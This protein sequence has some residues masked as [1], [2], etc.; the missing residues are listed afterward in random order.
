MPI[1][2]QSRT[3]DFFR[4]SGPRL[5]F[6]FSAWWTLVY[7]APLVIYL[8]IRGGGVD[9]PAGWILQGVLG[10]LG[11]IS[12]LAAM[13]ITLGMLAYLFMCDGSPTRK[14]IFWLTA[15]F[16]AAFFGASIYF[17]SVY[18]KQMTSNGAFL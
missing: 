11:L 1:I 17:F 6:H 2:R 8:L 9:H 13:A 4:K 10:I 16:I 5:L 14:K 18:K 7:T 15:F 12:A 3:E